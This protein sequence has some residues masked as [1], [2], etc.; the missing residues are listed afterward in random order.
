MRKLSAK[1]FRT[2]V[3]HNKV[4][5]SIKIKFDNNDLDMKNILRCCYRCNRNTNNGLCIDK[6]TK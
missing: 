4:K 3:I 1:Y 6:I 2:S 5:Y